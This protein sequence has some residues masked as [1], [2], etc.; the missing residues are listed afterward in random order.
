MIYAIVLFV[1]GLLPTFLGILCKIIPFLT[2]MRAY[3][4]KVGRGP[5]PAA[6]ALTHPALERWAFRILAIALVPLVAGAWLLNAAWL[7][8]GAWLLGLAIGLF[9]SDML[10]VLSHL[11]AKD[12]AVSP[13]AQNP[14]AK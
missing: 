6:S 10:G 5:T 8:A 3:G 7:T 14:T 2:W 4:P 13:A 9:L 12:A 11:R 1:G